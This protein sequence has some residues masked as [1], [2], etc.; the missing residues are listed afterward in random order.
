ML[1]TVLRGDLAVNQSKALIRIFKQMKDF[2]V[3]SQ[4][5]LSNPELVKLSLQTAENTKQIAQTMKDVVCV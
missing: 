2:I 3:Q 1:M 4:N 5:I